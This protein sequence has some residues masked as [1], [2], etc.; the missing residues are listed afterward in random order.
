[1]IALDA[2]EPLEDT[3]LAPIEETSR[4]DLQQDDAEA[5]DSDWAD[6]R[7]TLFATSA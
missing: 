7:H 5:L 1:M 2:T 6:R 4:E 3:G